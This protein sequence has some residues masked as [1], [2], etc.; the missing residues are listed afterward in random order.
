[1]VVEPD[2][3]QTRWIDAGADNFD[4]EWTRGDVMSG[5]LVYRSNGGIPR[6]FRMIE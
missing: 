4:S 5:F 3:S 1:M 2:G 6:A